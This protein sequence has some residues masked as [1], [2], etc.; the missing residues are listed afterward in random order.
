MQSSE[1]LRLQSMDTRIAL[2]SAL[3]RHLALCASI[4]ACKLQ[5]STTSYWGVMNDD[6]IAASRMQNNQRLHVTFEFN[7]CAELKGTWREK[8]YP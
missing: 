3:P 7:S 5:Y 4:Y 6:C 8:K 2:P 1:T